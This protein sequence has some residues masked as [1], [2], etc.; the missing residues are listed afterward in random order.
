MKI[1]VH[2]RNLKIDWMNGIGSLG[3]NKTGLDLEDYH[4]Y[5]NVPIYEKLSDFIWKSF[6]V[7]VVP[8]EGSNLLFLQRMATE[9]DWV[10]S[11]HEITSIDS[12]YQY[13]INAISESNEFSFNLFFVLK[14]DEIKSN[15]CW[16]YITDISAKVENLGI[17]KN[18][19]SEGGITQGDFWLY[20][21]LKGCL[22]ES[23]VTAIASEFENT[24]EEDEAWYYIYPRN[25]DERKLV[26]KYHQ[27]GG[28]YYLE[29]SSFDESYH[30][31][32]ELNMREVE[33]SK[34]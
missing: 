3:G 1:D 11:I 31:T 12:E 2:L 34:S 30:L 25:V 9:T 5:K 10:T 32:A 13:V 20:F 26:V 21:N 19:S 27:D 28:R 6:L 17:V 7:D 8:N 14:I 22:L 16:T 23:V 15:Q 18:Y 29:A 24:D 33:R 4:L